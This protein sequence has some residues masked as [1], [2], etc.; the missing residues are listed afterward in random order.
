MNYGCNETVS[1][2]EE[3]SQLMTMTIFLY[4]DPFIRKI[5]LEIRLEIY[6]YNLQLTCQSLQSADWHAT[7]KALIFFAKRFVFTTGEGFLIL[8]DNCQKL[9]KGW[10]YLD[11]S[12]QKMKMKCYALSYFAF[13]SERHISC[14]GMSSKFC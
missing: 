12:C 7:Y 5:V 8:G 3:I 11:K 6:K 2:C 4:S 9:E 13:N 14:P 1:R 10:N